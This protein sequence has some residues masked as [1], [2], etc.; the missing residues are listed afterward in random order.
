MHF[1]WYLALCASHALDRHTVIRCK[2]V[3]H[4]TPVIYLV[5]YAISQRQ[6]IAESAP[7][8]RP[9]TV[10]HSI[11]R[12]VRP[13]HCA[14]TFPTNCIISAVNTISTSSNC[15]AYDRCCCQKLLARGWDVTREVLIACNGVHSKCKTMRVYW[16]QRVQ[17]RLCSTRVYIAKRYL[18][19][20]PFFVKRCL[21]WK[22]TMENHLEIWQAKKWIPITCGVHRSLMPITDSWFIN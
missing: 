6:P 13:F 22:G 11:S 5:G 9:H 2:F 14:F 19:T 3:C 8:W 12:T 21:R 15:S 4:L 1:D 20:L 17:S 18:G 16:S 7:I 10:T